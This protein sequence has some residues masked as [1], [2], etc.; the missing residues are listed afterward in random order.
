MSAVA[1][2]ISDRRAEVV[3]WVVCFAFVVAAHGLGAVALLNEQ[4]EASDFGVD[5]PVVVVDLA[6]S[7]VT[8][9]VPLLDAAP[10]PME[11]E[12]QQIQPPKEETKPPEPEAE[13]TIPIPEPPKLELPSEEKFKHAPLP[14]IAPRA[15]V[16]RWQSQLATHLA[17]F[18]HYPDRALSRGNQGN[19]KAEFTI[20]REGHLLSS[21]VIQSTGS[22]TLDDEA[23]AMVARAQPLPRPPD[24]ISDA[25]LTIVF[26]INFIF[27]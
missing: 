16:T 12:I 26:P 3:R 23:L 21:R 2:M 11:E 1:N 20:D 14:A 9:M 25:E 4:T 19:G 15:L 5:T 24:G 7:L 27:K 17:R 10:G 18:K 13:V 8:R 6:D 22:A